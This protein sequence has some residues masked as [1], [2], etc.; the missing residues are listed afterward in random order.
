MF[1]FKGDFLSHLFLFAPLTQDHES[2]WHIQEAH[3]N[4]ENVPPETLPAWTERTETRQKM[5]A[6]S[7]YSAGNTSFPSWKEK[8]GSEGGT[9]TSNAAVLPLKKVVSK[10][11]GPM[12]NKSCWSPRVHKQRPM[13]SLCGVPWL[14]FMLTRGWRIEKTSYLTPTLD[15]QWGDTDDLSPRDTPTP[16]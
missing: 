10:R 11:S 14:N 15:T 5:K 1:T 4:F 2:S 8:S 9:D 13:G 7:C 6:S 16:F 3:N 12:N